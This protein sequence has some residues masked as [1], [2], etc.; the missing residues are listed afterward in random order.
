METEKITPYSTAHFS[1]HEIIFSDLAVR[2]GVD[3]TPPAVLLP[4]IKRQADFMETIRALFGMPIRITSWYRNSRVNF[5][6]RGSPN[7]SHRYG[8]AC[9][10]VIAA[11]GSPFK[12]CKAIEPHIIDLGIDQLINEFNAWTHI[13][14]PLDNR[15]PRHE[16]L[17][18][19]LVNDE[20]VYIPGILQ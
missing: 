17:T 20:T 10:F 13:S 11:Y 19:R 8:L 3:N 4:N 18:S 5:L 1:W 14:L 16:L 7:S 15:Q 9:D 6:A 12:V 2:Y